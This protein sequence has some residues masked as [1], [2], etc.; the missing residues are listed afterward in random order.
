M[1]LFRKLWYAIKFARKYNFTKIF[2]ITKV[3]H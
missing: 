1:L 3:K 2:S